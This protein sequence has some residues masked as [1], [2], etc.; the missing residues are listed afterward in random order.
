MRASPL[1]KSPS[2]LLHILPIMRRFLCHLAG[3]SRR[4]WH[5]VSATA[6]GSHARLPETHHLKPSGSPSRSTKQTMEE[7]HARWE[8]RAGGSW[9][10]PSAIFTKPVIRPRPKLKLGSEE[11]STVA[12]SNAKCKSFG[13]L[14]KPSR[15]LAHRSPNILSIG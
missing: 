1:P 13:R 10:S 11:L 4:P 5:T 9:P 12:P 15:R 8:S 7:S 3:A 14:K 6:D 2:H